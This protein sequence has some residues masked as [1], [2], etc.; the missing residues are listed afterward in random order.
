M[1]FQPDLT[2]AELAVLGE[3]DGLKEKLRF[4]LHEPRRW[5]GSL[6]RLSFARAIQGSNTIE[7]YTAELD[8]AAAVAAGEDPLDAGVETRMALRGY[9]D[10]M[11][12][13]LQ[14]ANEPDFY[15]SEH[16]I[17][18]LHFMMIGYDLSKSP[19]LYR[20]GTV[21]VYNSESGEVVYEG[22]PADSVPGLV[23]ELVEELN[24]RNDDHSV[25][26]AGMSHLNLVMIHP[27]RDGNGRMARALQSLV[28]ARDGILSPVFM[29][30][31]E[32]LGRNTQAYY[33]V[34]AEV[35]GGSWNPANDARPWI[36]FT[37]TAHLRQARTMLR[38]IRE[39]E[40]LWTELERIT[41]RE[42]LPDRVLAV[43][44]DAAIGFRVRNNTYRASIGELEEIS[45]ATASRDLGRLVD[46]GLLV[47]HGEKRGRFYTRGPT[48]ADV[49]GSIVQARDPKDDSDPFADVA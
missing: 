12:Y 48:L 18:S 25:I 9:R 29:S 26:K 34:L 1:I 6:R 44:F 20:P 14:L 8:D 39:S 3:I 36:R 35:G 16:L 19:G 31:E 17:K 40:R 38:R 7:G 32:Y 5:F 28:L 11:T 2:E 15:F 30:I 37:L 49:W 33:D 47:S 21:F 27:F 23:V 42:G 22:A 13:V 45:Q 4:Q 46:A 10:A 41:E 24:A 43:M